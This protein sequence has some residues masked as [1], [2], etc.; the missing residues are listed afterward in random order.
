MRP[1]SLR[2][3]SADTSVNESSADIGE[4]LGAVLKTAGPS[5]VG[6]HSIRY[7]TISRTKRPICFG[8]V[9]GLTATLTATAVVCG[10][11]RW[12]TVDDDTGFH[13]RGGRQRTSMDPL[14]PVS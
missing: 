2:E 3:D 8:Y 14:P 11:Q 4:R 1:V 5:L 7:A 9:S 6:S 13:A 12:A 10:G